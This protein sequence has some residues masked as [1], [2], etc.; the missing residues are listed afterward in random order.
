MQDAIY[1]AMAMGFFALSLAFME[2]LDRAV[3]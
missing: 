2:F 1:L 3:R